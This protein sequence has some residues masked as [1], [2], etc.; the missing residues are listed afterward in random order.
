MNEIDL[1][2]LIE[3]EP[4]SPSK[5]WSDQP[6]AVD[7]LPVLFD[8]RIDGRHTQVRKDNL[9]RYYLTVGS[10]FGSDT[11]FFDDAVDLIKAL[12]SEESEDE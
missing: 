8:G 4:P 3:K 10:L 6:D 9:G 11:R 12:N 1:N 7:G 5:T 2:A